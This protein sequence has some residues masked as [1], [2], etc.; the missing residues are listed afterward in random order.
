[1]SI[2]AINECSFYV[3]WWHHIIT[4]ITTF[5]YN[6]QSIWQFIVYIDMIRILLYYISINHPDFHYVHVYNPYL[7]DR[8]IIN[9]YLKS[10]HQSIKNK[11]LKCNDQSV[12]LM[13]FVHCWL[14]LIPSWADVHWLFTLTFRWSIICICSSICFFLINLY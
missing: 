11:C 4:I 8:R 13:Y 2:F 9:S 10:L 6:S 1:M 7:H 12:V 14:Y 5:K 3:M